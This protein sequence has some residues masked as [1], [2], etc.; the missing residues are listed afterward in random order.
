MSTH[1]SC[2]KP[3][4]KRLRAAATSASESPISLSNVPPNANVIANA[5]AAA[6]GSPDAA[7]TLPPPPI[8]RETGSLGSTGQSE[9]LNSNAVDSANTLAPD[10][11]H[12]LI[13]EENPDNTL[14]EECYHQTI[15]HVINDFGRLEAPTMS[16]A[17][18]AEEPAGH[19]THPN[20]ASL[21]Q[22]TPT[23]PDSG[24]I[25]EDDIFPILQVDTRHV[26]QVDTLINQLLPALENLVL[27]EPANR[28]IQ[29]LVTPDAGKLSP[30]VREDNSLQNG[31]SPVQDNRHVPEYEISALQERK[32]AEEVTAEN[33]EDIMSDDGFDDFSGFG[34][35]GEDEG[36]TGV[37]IFSTYGSA[38][39]FRRRRRSSCG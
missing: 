3:R 13:V 6:T 29:D 24:A 4:A 27:N 30:N 17:M 36:F 21:R 22:T 33:S 18:I 7:P 23:V 16:D 31:T 14:D 39:T 35:Y 9:N 19:D 5:N 26:P 1:P 12:T 2:A 8:D 25:M 10:H 37:G 11:E 32:P 15:P 34:G 28:P 20:D 38:L